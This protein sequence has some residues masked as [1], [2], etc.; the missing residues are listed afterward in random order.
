[1]GYEPALAL[2][3]LR[4]TVGRQTAEA[5]IDRVLTMLP[6]SVRKIRAVR[7]AQGV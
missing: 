6:E 4:L 1:M 5:D 3:S 7:E 2:G